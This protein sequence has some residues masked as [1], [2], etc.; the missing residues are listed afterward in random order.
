MDA[1]A[2]IAVDTAPMNKEARNYHK[3]RMQKELIIEKLRERRY[4]I[5]KQRLMLLDIILEEE[6]SS[7]KEIYYKALKK[8]SNMG[9]ATVYRMM[10]TLEEL[11]A[12]NRNSVYQVACAK[13]CEREDACIVELDDDT[14]YHLSAKSWNQVINE[15]LKSCGYI[16]RQN[17]RTVNCSLSKVII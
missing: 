2:D 12:I 7:C 16:D 5:T 15:G 11:G 6:C 4:R 14:V 8:D 9:T 3:T 1:T 17:I 10:N 13:D